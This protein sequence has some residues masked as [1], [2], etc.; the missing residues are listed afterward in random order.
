LDIVV[1]ENPFLFLYENDSVSFANVKVRVLHTLKY[2]GLNTNRKITIVLLGKKH[3]DVKLEETLGL[4]FDRIQVYHW[5]TLL[6]PI[7]KHFLVPKHTPI[8]GE[9]QIREIIKK[10]RLVNI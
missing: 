7:Q 2:H 1:D 9:E 5:T 10:Y 6:I 3:P 8:T 4:E